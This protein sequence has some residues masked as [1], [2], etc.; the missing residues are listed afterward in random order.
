MSSFA[1][2][3]SD[4]TSTSV[5]KKGDSRIPSLS[6]EFT[7]AITTIDSDPNRALTLLTSVA[8]KVSNLSLFSK[9]EELTDI[10]TNSLRYLLLPFYLAKSTTG[11]PEMNPHKRLKNITNATSLY[12]QYLTQ[13]LTYGSI[14]SSEDVTFVQN[15]VDSKGSSEIP[16]ILVD[17]DSKI[18]RFKEQKQAETTINNLQN[19]LARRGK[20]GVESEDMFEGNDAETIMRELYVEEMKRSAVE[21]IEEI[22]NAG[23]EV[24]M[25]RFRIG[26]EE[27]GGGGGAKEDTRAP[28][29][30]SSLPTTHLTKS[31][32]N[33]FVF[34]ASALKNGVFRPGWNLPTMSL[35]E[36]GEIEY[37]DAMARAEKQKEDEEANKGKARRYE[38]IVRDGLEDD[39][40]LVEKSAEEDRRWDEFKDSNKRGWGNKKGDVGDRN[41]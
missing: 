3:T 17:R 20:L 40:D 11:I 38:Y 32:I 31:N 18:R 34:K 24:E 6:E 26:R 8:L 30:H 12:Y 9:S 37:R 27:E 36:L 15:L 29:Q 7:V 25:L 35:E 13:C 10:S 16:T 19:M 23:R 28:P 14:I 4:S 39:E 5:T 2:P 21:A 22:G 41:F 1:S 33:E